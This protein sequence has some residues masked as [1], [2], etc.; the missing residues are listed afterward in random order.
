MKVI[1]RG[2]KQCP[3]TE[4]CEHSKPHTSHHDCNVLYGDA[5]ICDHDS[6]IQYQRKEKI[7]KLNKLK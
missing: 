5:C 4:I 7:N 6:F 1:C 3:V 2:R